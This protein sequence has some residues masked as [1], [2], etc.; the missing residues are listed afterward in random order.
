MDQDIF[1]NGTF[2]ECES[3]KWKHEKICEEKEQKEAIRDKFPHT[4]FYQWVTFVFA[5]QVEISSFPSLSL[6]NTLTGCSV[7]PAV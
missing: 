3:E 4:T 2:V 1:I 5:I 7:L 6:L